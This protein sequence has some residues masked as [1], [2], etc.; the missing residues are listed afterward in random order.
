MR[1]SACRVTDPGPASM[2]AELQRLYL[3]TSDAC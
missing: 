1:D 3:V 2:L